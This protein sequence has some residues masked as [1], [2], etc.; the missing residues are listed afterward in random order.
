YDFADVVDAGVGG[1]VHLQHIRMPALHD[2]GAVPAELAHVERRLVDA[3]A[4]VVEG[5]RQD[6]CGGGLTHAAHTGEHVTLGDAVGGER[7]P[8]RRH[9]G[10]LADQAGK[11]GWTVLARQHDVGSRLLG[12][13]ATAPA[14]AVRRFSLCHALPSPV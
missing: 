14:L 2:L 5:P 12:R 4:L 3:V 1:S 11:G 9:H 10:I 7:V 13:L 8:Q 6:A